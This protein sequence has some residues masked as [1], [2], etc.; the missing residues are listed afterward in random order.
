MLHL[1]I[2]PATA[3]TARLTYPYIPLPLMRWPSSKP[4]RASRLLPWHLP[5]ILV[6]I[7]TNNWKPILLIKCHL[8][9]TRAVLT[10]TVVGVFTYRCLAIFAHKPP[11]STFFSTYN[12]PFNAVA[13]ALGSSIIG[14]CPRP[15]SA[16]RTEWGMA[17]LTS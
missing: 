15:A 6:P 4:T 13:V 2:R 3:K 17:A 12:K 8:Y 10:Q 1:R 7:A 11:K 16:V 9:H 5:S 14:M